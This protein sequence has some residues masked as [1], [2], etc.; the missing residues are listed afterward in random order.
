MVPTLQFVQTAMPYCAACDTR[1]SVSA[2]YP[3][4]SPPLNPHVRGE[5]AEL[6]PHKE[7]AKATELTHLESALKT[8]LLLQMPE[9][10][11]QSQLMRLELPPMN[12]IHPFMVVSVRVQNVV[13]IHS[14][15]DRHLHQQNGLNHTTGQDRQISLFR[16]GVVQKQYRH[17]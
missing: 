11:N 17:E 14:N 16:S 1:L 7:I 5:D 6:A 9:C 13:V 12:L 2:L 4:P 15:H 8:H 10:R 3:P